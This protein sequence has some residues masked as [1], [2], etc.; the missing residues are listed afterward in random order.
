V[1]GLVVFTHGLFTA[2]FIGF[3]VAFTM[4]GLDFS[5]GMIT[6]L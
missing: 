6:G 3:G 4:T 1:L 5:C 2:I